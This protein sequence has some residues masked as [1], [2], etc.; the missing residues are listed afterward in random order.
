MHRTCAHPDCSVTFDDCRIHHVQFW[1]EHL[2]TTD[3]DNLVPVCERHHH[4]VH[5]GGWTL[6]MTPDRTTTWTR[7]DGSI[8]WNGSSID[9]TESARGTSVM[10][11]T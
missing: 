5:D 3:I 1:T 7:P 11:I 8:H 4:L 10:A 2:G 6:T 9:R